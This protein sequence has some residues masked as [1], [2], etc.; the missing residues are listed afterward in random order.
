M[1]FGHGLRAGQAQQSDRHQGTSDTPDGVV[2]GPSASTSLDAPR[3]HMK[4]IFFLS[5]VCLK[6]HS[7]G[8][9]LSSPSDLT[10][11]P[12]LY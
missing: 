12:Q 9:T 11:F 2:W 1:Y 3:G 6:S 4:N 5:S 7:S 10:V 8:Q